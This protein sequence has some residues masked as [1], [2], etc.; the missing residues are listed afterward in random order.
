MPNTYPSLPQ[1]IGTR[2]QQRTGI[3]ERIASNG[4]VRLRALQSANKSDPVV[5]HGLLNATQ[6]STFKTF[7]TN[8]RAI[9]FYF[10]SVE[11]GIQRTCV[12]AAQGYEVSTNEGG[13]YSIVVYMRE[14]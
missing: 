9:P 11:D 2:L 1:W 8:N 10:T 5:V 3:I 13:F 14:V 6:L 12:F 4:A 7:Y